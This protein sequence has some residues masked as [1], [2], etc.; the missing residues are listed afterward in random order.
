MLLL[1]QKESEKFKQ[2]KANPQKMARLQKLME[3][4]LGQDEEGENSDKLVQT[5]IKI[6]DYCA[7][8]VLTIKSLMELII[9]IM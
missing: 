7:T 1:K 8:F 4:Y 5:F 2:L 6:D 9:R 3:A